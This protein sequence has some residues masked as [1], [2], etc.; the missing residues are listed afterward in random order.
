MHRSFLM[1]IS[2]NGNRAWLERRAKNDWQQQPI[3]IYEIHLGS[4]KTIVEDGNRPFSYRELAPALVD[5]LK[6]M[7]YTHVEFMPLAEHPFDGSWGYQVTGFFAPTHRFGSPTDFMYLV[8]YLHQHGFGVLM[9]WVPAHFPK[10]G[11]ALAKFD[12]SCLYEHADPRQG[13]HA[14]WGT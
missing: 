3:S 7:H 4:W 6:S 13:E 11:F 2:I 8:D 10:D 1:S 9:D 5:Y 12:G 14:D